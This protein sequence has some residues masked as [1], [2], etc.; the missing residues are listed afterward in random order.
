MKK[1]TFGVTSKVI[2]DFSTCFHMLRTVGSQSS[3]NMLDNDN[4]SKPPQHRGPQFRAV[5]S[6]LQRPPE[7]VMPPR[8]PRPGML[9]AGGG[10]GARAQQV[11]FYDMGRVVGLGD[12]ASE[13]FCFFIHV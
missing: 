8:M 1:K 3:P 10:S 6:R 4:P 5:Q 11:L 9:Y 2:D 13:P 7:R 12:D